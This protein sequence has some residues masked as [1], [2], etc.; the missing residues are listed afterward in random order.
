MVIRVCDRC[1]AGLR[2][3]E[4]RGVYRAALT[5]P[6]GDVETVADFQDL[7]AMCVDELRKAHGVF[8][9]KQRGATRVG[10]SAQVVKRLSREEG[11]ALKRS[12][13]AILRKHGGSATSDQLTQGLLERGLVMP[14]RYPDRNLTS[15][16]SRHPEIENVEAGVWRLKGEDAAQ[17]RADV[18]DQEQDKAQGGANEEGTQ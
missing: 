14:G 18:P 11:R 10:G 15:Y 8:R 5:T 3:D 4:T 7:C 17:G 2:D 13:V 16:L 12:L 1:Q 9:R 6:N